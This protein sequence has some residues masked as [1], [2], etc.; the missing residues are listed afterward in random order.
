MTSCLAW[1]YPLSL[2]APH[3]PF[4]IVQSGNWSWCI[5]FPIV[6]PVSLEEESYLSIDAKKLGAEEEAWNE[7]CQKECHYMTFRSWFSLLASY[8]LCFWCLRIRRSS[9]WQAPCP[10]SGHLSL[11][12]LPSQACCG[13]AIALRSGILCV[14]QTAGQAHLLNRILRLRTTGG[15]ANTM[16]SSA[17]AKQ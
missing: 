3:T 4:S 6:S 16:I 5:R 17:S 9:F 11:F 15:R 10:S 13:R 8:G 14:H 2:C 1:R 12:S 7:G